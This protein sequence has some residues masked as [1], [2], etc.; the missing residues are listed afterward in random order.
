MLGDDV[1]QGSWLLERQRPSRCRAW[2]KVSELSTLEDRVSPAVT[3]E[4]LHIR[5]HIS[6]PETP[7]RNPQSVRAAARFLHRP[8]YDKLYSC[9]ILYICFFSLALSSFA[10]SCDASAWFLPPPFPPIPRP[11]QLY[12]PRFLTL[13]LSIM[14]AASSTKRVKVPKVSHQ[15]DLNYSRVRVCSLRAFFIPPPSLP[16]SLWLFHESE[17]TV[18]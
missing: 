3:P 15:D 9:T 1:L 4:A 2:R 10:Y 6:P 13:T 17:F 16:P 14:P 12:C 7:F 8:A 5:I 11:P 18:P